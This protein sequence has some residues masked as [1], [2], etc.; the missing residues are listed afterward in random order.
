MATRWDNVPKLNDDVVKSFKE[1]A[2]KA[3]KGRNVDSSKL[4]GGARE[5]V[6]EAG[7]RASNRNIGRGGMPAA[8]LGIGYG[9]GRAIDEK[10]GVGKKM[11]EKSG[12]GDLIDKA[13]NSRDKVELSKEAKERI[14]AG[15]LEEKAAPKSRKRDTESASPEGKMRPGRNEEIDDETRENAGGYK[16]GGKVKKMASGGMTASKRADGIA[17]RGKTKCKMY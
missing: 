14:D 13:I 6:R 10:T 7:A 1:D 17:S 2:A 12:V 8:A 15:E 9:I 5:A 3:Q 11:V 4:T 16:R